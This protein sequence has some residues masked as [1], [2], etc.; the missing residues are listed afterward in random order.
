[1]LGAALADIARLEDELEKRKKRAE[2]HLKLLL[3]K[4]AVLN[5]EALEDH[6]RNVAAEVEELRKKKLKEIEAEAGRIR[7]GAERELAELDKRAARR[8][9]KAVEKILGV[10]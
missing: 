5:A 8:S 6:R 4:K 3:K 7:E 9:R 10:L 1:M 2:A